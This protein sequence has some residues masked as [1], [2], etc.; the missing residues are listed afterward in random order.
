MTDSTLEL[1]P[2]F[3]V[4][5]APAAARV[6]LVGVVAVA[7]GGATSLG[8]TFLP[9]EAASL[10]NSVTG[11]TLPTVALVF[12]TARS[13]TEAAVAGAVSFVALT[14]GYAVVSTLRGFPFDPTTWAVIG[15]LAGPV[16]GAATIA[17]RRSRMHAA[18]GGG[19]LA[20]VLIGEGVYGL[21]AIAATT[22]PVFW[23][24]AIT[25]GVGLLVAVAALRVR[26]LR[27]RL[28]LV[29]VAGLTASLFVV[30]YLALP[31]VFGL[32]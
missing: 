28:V 1:A 29:S 16:I 26:D 5:L 8:Q 32:L 10:A 12:V 20:G 9:E 2:R 22:G 21:T 25:V 24:A 15:L 3:R 27:S 18:V 11:W 14:V 23:W 19:L 7:L 30:A 17:L 31:S 13:S 4:T 6:L